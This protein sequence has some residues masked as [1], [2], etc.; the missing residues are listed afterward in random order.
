MKIS[1]LFISLILAFAAFAAEETTTAGP[2]TTAKRFGTWGFDLDGMD[3]SVKPGDDWFKYANGK[4]A[5]STQIPPDRVS[6]GVSVSLVELSEARV[7]AILDSLAASQGLKAGSDE[8]KLA[9]LYRT[10]L[11][12]AALEK[13]DAKPLQP[14]LD[15]ARKARTHADLA[16]LLGRSNANFGKTYFDAQVSDD[17]KNPDKYALYLSQGTLGLPDRDYYLKNNFKPQKERY[18]K[19]VADMLRMA[20]WDDPDKSAADIVAFESKVAEAQW[21]RSESRDRDKTYNPMTPAELAKNA[22]GFPW[23]AYFKG[24]WLTKVERAVV[25]EKTAF[26]KLAQI[27]ADTPVD[28][29]KAWYAFT[30]TD[31]AAPYLSKRFV[32]AAW[33]FRSKFLSGAREQR[34]RWK[35]A[36]AAAEGAMGEAI[37]RKY[38]TEYFPPESKAK[39]EKL[40]ADCGRR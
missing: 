29:L 38:V 24:A 7:R 35:R 1:A 28:T 20:G 21:S 12:E 18:Q 37:G 40:V 17:A 23:S 22:P 3:R 4:W 11:D 19:Y 10:F 2:A 32:D 30:V 39:M 25:A 33:E 26:P 31:Q 9:A 16:E 13:I 14:Q 5:A 34:P 27:Y 6:Y 36:V 8:A 15:E